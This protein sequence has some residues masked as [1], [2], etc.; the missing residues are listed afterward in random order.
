[1]N[2]CSAETVV[3]SAV[4]AA[5]VDAVDRL[6]ESDTVCSVAEAV[7]SCVVTAESLTVTGASVAEVVTAVGAV[8]AKVVTESVCQVV[9]VGA[10]AASVDSVSV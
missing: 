9:S 2:G 6:S 1:M 8:D 4:C 3:D 5:V 10:V 7:G